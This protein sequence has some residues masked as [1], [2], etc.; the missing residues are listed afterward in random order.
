MRFRYL[1][2]DRPLPRGA[3]LEALVEELGVSRFNTAV[4]ISDLGRTVLDEAELQRRVQE[5]I[6]TR[7]DSWLWLI[8]FISALASIASALA[9]WY[10]ATLKY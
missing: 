10:I 5:A 9:A 4:H 1:F 3:E 6:R 7:R 8:A 2:F